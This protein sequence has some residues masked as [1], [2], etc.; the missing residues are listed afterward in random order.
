MPSGISSDKGP[1]ASSSST[2]PCAAHIQNGFPSNHVE[3]SN[4]MQSLSRCQGTHRLDVE[5]EGSM[6]FRKLGTLGRSVLSVAG[7]LLRV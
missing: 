7:V 4:D 3:V 2:I 6:G 5:S 1:N